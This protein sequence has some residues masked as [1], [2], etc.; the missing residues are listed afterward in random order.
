MF[1]FKNLFCFYCLLVLISSYPLVCL[2]SDIHGR[3]RRQLRC[4]PGLFLAKVR[5]L[6]TEIFNH[7]FKGQRCS[8]PDHTGRA[9]GTFGGPSQGRARNEVFVA[10]YLASLEHAAMIHQ[11]LASERAAELLSLVD[12]HVTTSEAQNCVH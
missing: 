5:L 3:P 6:G 12:A 9:R 1:I 7:L 4:N 8:L 11:E 10:H 2:F